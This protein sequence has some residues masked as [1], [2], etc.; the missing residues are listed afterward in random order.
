MRKEHAPPFF[1]PISGPARNGKQFGC[2]HTPKFLQGA[3]PAKM[4]VGELPKPAGLRDKVSRSDIATIKIISFMML[5]VLPHPVSYKHI[6]T[7]RRKS[8]GIF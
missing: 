6:Q 2:G 1:A 7:F 8:H 5:W 3:G 4:L